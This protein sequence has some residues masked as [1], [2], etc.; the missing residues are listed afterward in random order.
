MK[1]FDDLKEI[2]SKYLKDIKK[3]NVFLHE[4]LFRIENNTL[5]L[6]YMI[7]DFVDPYNNNYDIKR[8][9]E[10]LLQDL[11]TGEIVQFYNSNKKDFCS[12]NELPFDKTFKNNGTSALYNDINSIA[13]SFDKW[14]NEEIEKLTKKYN[15]QFNP[16]NQE[17]VLQLGEDI[18][19]PKNYILANSETVFSKMY[20]ELFEFGNTITEAYKEFQNNLVMKVIRDYTEKSIINK[21]VIKQYFELV[22]YSYP[23]SL[24]LFNYFNNISDIENNK[25][26]NNL[27]N[28]SNYKNA[29]AIEK[30]EIRLKEID[31]KY[32]SN[33]KNI[34]LD[35][36]IIKIDEKIKEIN[37]ED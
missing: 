12:K 33:T 5:Y 13:I 9:T 29:T 26:N 7:I 3:E 32:N 21:E 25:Y 24:D 30:V 18:V 11:V 31:N 20:N 14:K 19:S 37:K 4:P 16:I 8:P 35:D 17:N 15:D 1:T 36:L 27:N 34:N 10:W 23:E 22:K 6:G 2:A 28:M